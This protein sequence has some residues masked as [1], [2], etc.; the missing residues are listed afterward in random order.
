MCLL[1]TPRPR[2]TPSPTPTDCCP[3]DVAYKAHARARPWEN[4][5]AMFSSR[6]GLERGVAS[7]LKKHAA[8]CL[9]P[10]T[11]LSGNRYLIVAA[12]RGNFS[13]KKEVNSP[14]RGDLLSH[15]HSKE[16]ERK[17]KRPSER[18]KKR[19]K[20]NTTIINLPP[21]RPLSLSIFSLP[22]TGGGKKRREE[23]GA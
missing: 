17:K 22:H 15:S 19:E 21:R 4:R 8:V 16:G 2:H 12:F 7:A 23:R 10:E 20:P 11:W 14:K 3:C 6:G 5:T 1:H 9:Q 18:M 13:H